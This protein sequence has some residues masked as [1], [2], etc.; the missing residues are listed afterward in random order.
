MFKI[1]EN[2]K[3]AHDVYSLKI[4]ATLIANKAKAGNFVIIKNNE[5]GE[6]FPLTLADWN[7][8]QGW[9]KVVVQ[10]I[11]F[12]T[13]EL[14]KL[15]EIQDILGPLGNP[16]HIENYGNVAIVVGG[17]GNAMALA[18][19]KA[20][21]K[22][23]NNVTVIYGSRNKELLFW[24]NEITQLADKVIVA[25]DDGSYGF[26][27]NVVDALKNHDLNL[28]FI[29]TVGPPIMMK[30]VSM[31]AKENNIKCIASLTSIMIDGMGMC[32]GCRLIVDGKTKFACVDGPEFDGTKVDWSSVMNRLKHYNQETCKLNDKIKTM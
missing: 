17:L 8:E 28:D 26:H 1:I 20:F 29:L 12:S 21:K 15:N 3:L 14:V 24:V 31:Y 11:G 22:A 5:R 7:S 6:R 10:A 27:G 32:G 30:F 23:G 18:Q 19:I 9:I 13:K 2:I 4:N 25:T 16:T